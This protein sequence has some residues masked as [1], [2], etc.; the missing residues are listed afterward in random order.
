M[1]HL[2]RSWFEINNEGKPF[3]VEDF[4]FLTEV[5]SDFLSR[6]FLEFVFICSIYIYIPLE[7]KTQGFQAFESSF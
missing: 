7:G 1:K 5:Y 2:L 3:C 4:K 6:V